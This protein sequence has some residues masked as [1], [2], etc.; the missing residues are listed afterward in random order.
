MYFTDGFV[1]GGKP[2]IMIKVDSV[3]T[4]DDRM[5][6]IL[7][8]NGETRLFD[9]SLLSGEVF[10]LLDDETVFSDCKID[11]GVPTWH[12]GEIDCAPEYLYDN[13]YEYSQA[14]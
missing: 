6:L 3:K 11:H 4:L 13:S 12:N 5:M 7:F 10:K 9:A 8:N 14:V 1:C 2:D